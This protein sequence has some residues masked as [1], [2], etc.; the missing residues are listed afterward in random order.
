MK[1]ASAP[2]MYLSREALDSLGI[3]AREAA[4][5]V[6]SLIKRHAMKQAW[7]APKVAITTPDGRYLN[8]MLAAADDPAL[9]MV[10]AAALHPQNPEKGLPIIN[11]SIT[12][13]DSSTGQLIAVIDGN[14]V[15]AIRTAALSAV[16][17]L[18][19]ARTE[20]RSLAFIGCGVQA[21]SHLRIF[22]ELFPLQ[23]IRAFSRSR[24]NA[25]ILCR[26]AA[27]LGLQT[28]IAQTA[29]TAMEAA[30]IVASAVTMTPSLPPFIDA[31]W[32]Q[33]GSLAIGT[34]MPTSWI[35]HKM[36]GFD[37]IYVDDSAQE[38]ALSSPLARNCLIFADLTD[39]VLGEKP[40]RTNDQERLAF[41]FRGLSLADLALAALAYGKFQRLA[42][43]E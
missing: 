22:S 25:N 30:D 12:L 31:D 9:I 21:Q 40:G 26:Q 34:D 18:R 20:P 42:D 43:G 23:E 24:R 5:A 19:L 3:T 1:H 11:A 27:H 2:F 37:R 10:K 4:D 38:A 32:M 35:Y 14:W 41:M 13:L 7:A 33:P 8:A 36:K 39:L 17:A 29:Q 16:A 6:E 15:T 28:V